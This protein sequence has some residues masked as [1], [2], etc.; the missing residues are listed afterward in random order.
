MQESGDRSQEKMTDQK[1][2]MNTN[3]AGSSLL[4]T[5]KAIKTL[6]PVSDKALETVLESRQTIENILSRKDKRIFAVIG[7][8]SIHDTKAALEY[9]GKLKKLA[10]RV[11]NKIFILM[12]VYFEKPRTT[13]GWKG[14][15]NDPYMD[16]SFHM[17]EGLKMA[18]KLLLDFNE[19]GLPTATEA[20]DPI[21]PQYLSELI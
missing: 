21:T 9:A 14:L 3:I 12:R 18:R 8:C 11:K 16:D 5:P 1:K 10:D 4:I 15:I 2:L 20:L 13:I 6:F 7:P 17:E 19:M